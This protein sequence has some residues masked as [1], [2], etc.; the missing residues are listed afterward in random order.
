MY[1]QDVFYKIIS[2]CCTLLHIKLNILSYDFV[3]ELKKGNKIRHITNGKFD[4][5]NEAAA[6]IAC[7]KYATYEVL[8]NNNVPVIE[9][10]Q[11][12]NPKTRNSYVASIGNDELIS[13]YVKK[14]SK[15]VVKP[16]DGREGKNVFLCKNYM[17]TVEAIN[18]LFN[19]KD[20]CSLC[21]F[22]DIDT[23]YRSF[24]LD[25]KVYLIYGKTKPYVIGDGIK[26]LSELISD[27]QIPKN[28]IYNDNMKLLDM[29]Y[30]PKSG[31]KVEISWKFNLSGGA[32]PKILEKGPIYDRI[33]KLAIKAGKALNLT[34]ATIDIVLTKD[35]HL[36][37]LEA[38]SSIG[39]KIFTMKTENGYE[40]MKK[41]YMQAIKKMFKE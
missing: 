12:F 24:Y 30:V 9:H 34:F 29:D 37:V 3:L 10:V 13:S 18:K 6:A 31:E 36:Y 28:D 21:P 1:E 5:N 2:E 4:L 39:S 17:D 8:K 25:G 20:N 26:K 41:I 27:I 38:N 32:S 40:I 16:N 7:D 35:N 15:V 11:V 33:K 14:Y 22:Y 19:K 23:E